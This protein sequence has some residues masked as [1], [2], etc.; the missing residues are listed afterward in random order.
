MDELLDWNCHAALIGD[1]A[2]RIRTETKPVEMEA[3][4]WRRW[5]LSTYCQPGHWDGKDAG[6]PLPYLV[7]TNLAENGEMVALFENGIEPFRTFSDERFGLSVR[8]VC[9]PTSHSVDS[10]WVVADRENRVG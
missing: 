6:V 3:D 10:R 2:C 8:A 5:L 7:D 9:L 1:A 4:E